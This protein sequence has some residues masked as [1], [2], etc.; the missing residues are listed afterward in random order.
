M[1]KKITNLL[2]FLLVTAALVCMT[3]YIGRGQTNVMIY[4]FCF[5]GVMVILYL[6][7]MFG[8]MFRMDDLAGALGRAAE[9]VTSIFK[10]PGKVKADDLNVLEGVFDN[11]YLDK[12]LRDFTDD[13]SKT[14][15]GIGDIEDYIN[16]DELDIHVHKR[17]MEMVPDIFTSLGILGTFVGLVWGLKN[18]SPND[19]AAMTSS[20]ASLVDGIKV[21]FLTSIYGIAFSIVYSYGAKSEYSAMAEKLQMF[22]N[23][24]HSYVMPNAEN[25]SRNLLVSSQK[26][27]TDAMNKMAEQFS[28][29]MADS[30]EK[31]ITPTFVKMNDSLDLL[32]SSVTRCQTDAIQ[33]I[34]DGFMKQMRDSFQLQFDDFNVALDEM[35]NSMKQTTEYNAKLYQ[36]LSRQLSDSYQQQDKAMR[37]S[38]TQ[39]GNLQNRYMQ[40]A[41]KITQD[42]QAIQR[43]QQQ[44]YEHVMQYMKEAES[45]AAKFWVACNQTM[46]RYV[47]AATAGMESVSTTNQAG[48]QVVDTNKRL[49]ADFTQKMQEFERY[50]KLSYETMD[51]VRRLL[52]DI[53]ANSTGDVYL[54]SGRNS[55]LAQQQTLDRIEQLLETQNESQQEM[56]RN[57]RDLKKESAQKGKFNL[58]K[59]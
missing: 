28:E 17:L 44:D 20:V 29:Q 46:K 18:F 55:S 26:V 35:T 22:L 42:N 21:A 23:R 11:R 38:V 2:L 45:S 56:A 31:V 7:G 51:E 59:S 36:S 9:E 50:Q 40:T 10:I 43:A 30:F 3:L 54:G 57:V 48:M 32:A 52:T 8:G 6:A 1:G 49:V 47:E 27:Q 24:F 19:Y 5:M 15:E 53:S 25:D 13:I 14:Q 34:V 41:T 39:I 4:N 12:K 33:E 16:E 37:E 58:F